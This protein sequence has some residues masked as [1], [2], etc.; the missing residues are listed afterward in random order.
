MRGRLIIAIITTLIYEAALVVLILWG[1]P[2]LGVYL[3]LPGLVILMLA[4]AAWAV[5]LYWKGT[6]AMLK[7][8]IIGL[9]GM[10]GSKA[11]V[12][13][14]LAPEGMVKI[15][16]ELWDAVSSGEKIGVGEEVEVVGQK[17][18]KLVV[19]KSGKI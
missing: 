12:V 7:K 5:A 19:R 3:P 15:R 14:R 4:L 13:R 11:K 1:L 10:V 18:L 8:E 6:Q 17:R 2:N 16:G 9:P